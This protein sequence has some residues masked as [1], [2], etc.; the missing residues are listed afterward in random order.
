LPNISGI[1]LERGPRAGDI[2]VTTEQ[3]RR[4]KIVN[5]FFDVENRLDYLTANGDILP[6]LKNLIP[7]EDFRSELEVIYDHERKS[8]AEPGRCLP[9]SGRLRAG[10]R[11][12]FGQ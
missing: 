2:I 7:W 4:Q 1:I 6:T 9:L 10:S 3:H 12:L 11:R 5:G 8:N